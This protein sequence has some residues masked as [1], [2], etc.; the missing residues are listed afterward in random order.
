MNKERRTMESLF[1]TSLRWLTIV[2]FGCL[3]AACTA[4]GGPEV[5]DHEF[6]FNMFLDNQDAV[7]LDY[8]YGNS[9]QPG[10]INPDSMRNQGKA[11]QQELIH[12]R[13][14]RGDFLYVKWRIKSTG[15][16]YEDT[17]DLRHR[18][19]KDITDHTITFLIR[20]PQLYVYLVTPERRAPDM[21]PNGPKEFSYL[22]VITLYPDQIKS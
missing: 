22:K 5:V 19:P 1:R 17:V 21:S 6:E 9:K 13:M 18:L 4:F 10:A 7:V 16:V 15:E 12:G 3:L 14:L 2:I 8:R 11:H 20:G